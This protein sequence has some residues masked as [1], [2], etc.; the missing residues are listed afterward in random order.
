MSFIYFQYFCLSCC[1]II[2]DDDN[3]VDNDYDNDYDDTTVEEEANSDDDPL[4]LSEQDS[5]F[6]DNEGATNVN[7]EEDL[8]PSCKLFYRQFIQSLGGEWNAC[9]IVKPYF[10]Q[11][12][13]LICKHYWF[14][15]I[16]GKDVAIG[17]VPPKITTH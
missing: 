4:V 17:I 8:S 5:E 3:N 6:N 7:I 16:N 13:Q 1:S 12:F 11:I 10:P 14:F 2:I 9:E 15:D